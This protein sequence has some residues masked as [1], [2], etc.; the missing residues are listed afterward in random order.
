M[1][2]GGRR[3]GP[4]VLLVLGAVVAVVG[5]VTMVVGGVV[6][7]DD[8]VDTV[9]NAIDFR[10]DLAVEVDL[11]G[12]ATFELRG[13][14]EYQVIAIGR[15]LVRSSTD[16]GG[17]TDTDIRPFDVPEVTITDPSGDDVVLHDPGV[18]TTYDSGVD[19]VVIYEFDAVD[20]GRYSIA[21]DGEPSAV[22]SV[23]VGES[24]ELEDLAGIFGGAA[25]IVLGG[26][27]LGMGIVMLV[28]GAIWLSVGGGSTTPRP[29]P[30]GPWGGSGGWPAP[31][32]GSGPQPGYGAPPGYGPP[33]G[34]PGW[35]G[36][37][38]GWGAAPGP[39]R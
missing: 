21:V 9:E 32:P 18:S 39:V 15:D 31:P 19:G 3:R 11:P 24:F 16:A 1:A 38:P 23:G 28:A 5:V 12:D 27:L 13:G 14:D 8:V 37:P 30:S 35:G 29:P 10:D 17:F 26:V 22:T 25:A 4:T 2:S 20:S 33:P 6:L 36:P 7:G 34:P